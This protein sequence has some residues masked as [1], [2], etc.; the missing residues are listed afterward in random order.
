MSKRTGTEDFNLG[1]SRSALHHAAAMNSLCRIP[2]RSQTVAKQKSSKNPVLR[3][4][5]HV[6]IEWRSKDFT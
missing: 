2:L 6:K 3:R 5:V 4:E 1:D